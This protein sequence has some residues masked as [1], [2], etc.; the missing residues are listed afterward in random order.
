MRTRQP[1]NSQL[2]GG[3]ALRASP[4][5]FTL[6]Y[7]CSRALSDAGPRGDSST[8]TAA[9]NAVGNLMLLCP[10]CHDI[11]DK[12]PADYPV[13]RL[14]AMKAAHEAWAQGLRHS[15][16]AWNVRYA[17]IDYVNVPRIV[18]LPGGRGI[19]SVAR[20]VGLDDQQPFRRQALRAGEFLGR[21]RPIF[22]RWDAQALPLSTEV[23]RQLKH[24]MLV[25]F[26]LPVRAR[27]ASRLDHPLTHRWEQDPHLYCTLDGRDVLIRFVPAWLTTSTAGTDLHTAQREPTVYAGLA[28]VV[29]VTADTI[30]LSAL[31]FGRPATAVH[32]MMAYMQRAPASLP[33]TLD[34]ADFTDDLSEGPPPVSKRIGERTTDGP[35]TI[36]VALHVDE[37]KL[38]P[39]QLERETFPQLLR[40]VPQYRRDVRIGMH[41]LHL[42]GVDTADVALRIVAGRPTLWKTISVPALDTM[43]SSTNI[44]VMVVQGIQL[45]QAQALHEIL[46]DEVTSYQGTLQ[47]D[48]D[49][50]LHHLLYL[51]EHPARYRI[52]EA[53]LRLLYSAV[54]CG[55]GWD[56]RPHD[57][58]AEW[59]EWSLFERVTWEEDAAQS[60]E[61]RNIAN[62]IVDDFLRDHPD[63]DVPNNW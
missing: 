16:H 2:A 7:F 21:V 52:V 20:Q 5:L 50:E 18:M 34:I 40:V 26:K 42:P 41:S 17:S 24:G 43:L 1:L 60:A 62:G 58:L 44:A 51:H 57:V 33:R 59:Q 4:G 8:P 49:S 10:S 25:A 47:L 56:D 13:E 27:N 22:E 54:R 37:D 63:K 23:T 12:H 31:V 55:P 30:R 9:R 3:D 48:P 35:T 19:G 36:T 14:R 6:P 11:V 28:I 29:G 15:G 45:A 61:D 32:S 53:E 46:S 39:G 38:V